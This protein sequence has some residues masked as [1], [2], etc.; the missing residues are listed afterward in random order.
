M[1]PKTFTSD[2][3][4][5]QAQWREGPRDDQPL[6]PGHARPVFFSFPFLEKK[7]RFIA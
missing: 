3:S 6:A 2:D 4:K 5:L 1:H 7:N